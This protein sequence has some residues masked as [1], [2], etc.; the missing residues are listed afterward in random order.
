MLTVDAVSDDCVPSMRRLVSDGRPSSRESLLLILAVWYYCRQSK[1]EG[2]GEELELFR[3]DND[4]FHD[5]LYFVW[6]SFFPSE[7][8]ILLCVG[9]G[10]TA[11]NERET[12]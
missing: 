1:Q 2:E 5:V 4:G 6:V 12:C 8:L 7:M 3:Q 10:K 9:L 11:W